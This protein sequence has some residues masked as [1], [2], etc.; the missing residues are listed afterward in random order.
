MKYNAEEG[1]EEIKKRGKKIRQRH[2]QWVRRVLYGSTA[3]LAIALLGVLGMFTGASA[4][5]TQ[6]VYGAFLLSA[7]SGGYILTALLAFSVG[8]LGALSVTSFRMKDDG[9]KKE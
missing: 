4:V 7:E 2:E 8:V 5:G 9:E 3:I 1:F 6:T